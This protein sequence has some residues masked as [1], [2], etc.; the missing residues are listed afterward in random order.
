MFITTTSSQ[1]TA[2]QAKHI[3]AFLAD[4]MPRLEKF[5]GVKAV[6]HF[7]RPEHQDDVTL[8]IWED[9]AA[10]QKYRVSALFQE[11]A[12]FENAHQSPAVREGFPLVYPPS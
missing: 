9:Q 1:P 11:A 3:E 7:L 2:E 8:I 10:M 6:Y 5:P 4:F 12:A